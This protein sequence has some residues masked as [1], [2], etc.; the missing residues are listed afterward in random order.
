MGTTAAKRAAFDR[1]Y[2][3]AQRITKEDLA[4]YCNT[5]DGLPHVVCRGGQKNFERFMNGIKRVDKGWEPAS[6]EYHIIVGKAILFL[7]TQSLARALGIRAFGINIVA[8][9]IALLAEATAKRLEL[10]AVWDRQNL[11]P[12]LQAQLTA[13]LPN[14]AT[15][16]LASAGERNPGEWFK[17]EQCWREMRAAAAGWGVSKQLSAELGSVGEEYDGVPEQVHHNVA[18]CLQVDAQGWFKIQ[19]WGSETKQLQP[20]QIGIANTLAGY[21]AQAWMRKPSE[22]QARQAVIILEL[23]EAAQGGG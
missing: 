14:A 10:S 8:Y 7:K 21:A 16:L 9:T 23:Y 18:R 2:P 20:W 1:K 17:S 13:W 3:S 4:R 19:L 5:W 22:K 15:Q 11:S 6:A 12:A